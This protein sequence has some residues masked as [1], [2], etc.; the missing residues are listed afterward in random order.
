MLLNCCTQYASK[1]GKL[2][3]GHRTGKGQFS[4]QSQRKAMPKNVQTIAQLHS[5]TSKEM[6]K[7]LQARLQQYVNCELPDVQA[8][9]RKGRGIRDQIANI[10][11]IMEKA[12]EFQKNIYFCFIDYA[13]AFDCVDHNK[14]R[15]ILKE[16]GIPDHLTCLLRNL[17][18]GQEA[19]VR[20]GHETTDWFQ[21]GKGVCQGCILSPCLFNLYAEYIMRNTGLDEAQAGIKIAKRN[22]NNLRYADDTTP[23]AE[24]KEELKSLVMKV[25]EESEKVGLKLNIQKTK[26]MASGPV[27]SWQID[28]EAVQTVADFIFLGSKITADGDCSHEIKRCLLLGRKVMTNLD[29]ILKSRDII[30][31]TKVRLVKAMVFPVVMYGCES[32]TIKKLSA[33]ELMLLNCGFEDS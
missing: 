18:A 3:S 32:W 24:S 26:I 25:K 9:F 1:F 10:C 29:S 21:T 11:W 17:Y 2:S 5:H 12:R 6:L 28:G 14:L 20:T 8:G 13:K 33:E 19:T 23:V 30:L 7:I 27:A 31:S 16:M 4:F 22:I 15:K